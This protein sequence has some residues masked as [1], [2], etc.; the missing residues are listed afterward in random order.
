[1]TGDVE[2][3]LILIIWY[4]KRKKA[5]FAL[6]LS[7]I[8]YHDTTQP[9]YPT[10]P[11]MPDIVVG[12]FSFDPSKQV[13]KGR[14]ATVYEGYHTSKGTKV[15]VKKVDWSSI[16]KNKHDTLKKKLHQALGVQQ[17]KVHDNVLTLLDFKV[18][19][20]SLPFR[21]LIFI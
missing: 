20:I 11:S 12:E 6:Q 4:C 14:H 8:Y 19:A 3:K 13:G 7:K 21:V 9:T 5:S 2:T 18:C 17:K 10:A 15:A 1:M 16:H